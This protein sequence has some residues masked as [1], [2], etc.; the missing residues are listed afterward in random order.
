MA[1]PASSPADK[2]R[3][4]LEAKEGWGLMDCGADQKRGAATGRGR[5]AQRLI[6]GPAA[7]AKAGRGERAAAA[8]GEEAKRSGG[9]GRG[10]EE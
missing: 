9:N 2:W 3:L 1:P 7:T 8:A 5:G 6:E 4:A 10:A